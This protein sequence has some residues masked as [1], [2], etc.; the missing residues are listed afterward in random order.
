MNKSK[1]LLAIMAMVLCVAAFAGG[2][3]ESSVPDGHITLR[4]DQ[5]SG[6]RDIEPVLINMIAEFNKI[7]PEIN[8]IL[9][10]FGYDEYF[11]QLQTRIVGGTAADIFELNFENFAM[12]ASENVLLDISGF[13]GD[14]SG[15][16][17][18][19]LDAF[20]YNGRQ[21]AVPNSFSN[22][23][24]F[25]NKALFDRAGVSYPDNNWTWREM[26]AA[27]QR[28]RALD[29]DIFGF[30]RPVSFHEFYKASRQNSSSLISGNRFTVNT[31][32]NIAAL[33]RMVSWQRGTNIMPTDAQMGGGGS[34]TDWALFTSGRLGMIVTGIWAF[35][36]FMNNTT[37][38]WDIAV[39][40][41]NTQKATHFFSNAY[42][43]NKE[44]KHPEAAAVLATFLAGSRE[45]AMLRVRASWELPPVNYPNVLETYLT[46]TPP[47]NRNAVFESLTYLVT[48]PVVTQ[49]SEMEDIISRHIERV[50]SGQVSA[51]EALDACQ[52][53]LMQRIRL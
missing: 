26:E 24:L 7:H 25:Y 38:P 3:R 9:Q 16:N 50:I 21:Y 42:A 27:A 35:D 36:N 46:I 23:V 51:K 39:E 43:V 47:A 13:I 6:N 17:K 20:K 29:R 12:Y 52:N 53:E 32:E 8:V 19:A 37:F 48:P 10:S 34:M 2:T 45:A 33:E 40:P 49:Q 22:V 11:T 1:L 30:Y 31:P 14:T 18:T 28:I 15:F 44:C 4:L 5:F 41:G